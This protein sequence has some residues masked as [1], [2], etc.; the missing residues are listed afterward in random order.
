MKSQ[1]YFLILLVILVLTACH[2]DIP[3][4]ETKMAASTPANEETAEPLMPVSGVESEAKDP[5]Y[6]RHQIKGKDVLV[7]CIVQD[8]S[9]RKQSSKEKGKIILYLNGKK[10]EEIHSAAFIIKGLPSGKH[11]I[12]LELVKGK[13]ADVSLK[14]DFIVVIP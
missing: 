10:K 5:F 13:N 7:E 12:G 2:K 11:R 6:V 9:F 1:K 4:P 14:R 8:V 3:E